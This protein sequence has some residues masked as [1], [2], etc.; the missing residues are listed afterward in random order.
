M[1]TSKVSSKDKCLQAFVE[2]CASVG[3]RNIT[4]QKIAD[5]AELSFGTVRYNFPDEA[6]D[7]ESEAFEYVLKSA[8]NLIE[9]RIESDRSQGEI[10]DPLQ[11]YIEA[12]FEWLAGN[13][14]QG[15]YLLYMYYCGTTKTSLK[16]LVDQTIAKARSRIQT[17]YLEG[18]GRKLYSSKIDPSELAATI[19]SLVVGHG[20]IAL[21]SKNIKQFK[22]EKTHC[23]RALEQFR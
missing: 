9:A 23:L 17:L 16:P 15:S 11:T 7:I 1:K 21:A 10:P 22:L 20:F 4:L 13:R 5:Q 19:H 8:Y 18:V 12:M 2:L 6:S 14:E 3:I